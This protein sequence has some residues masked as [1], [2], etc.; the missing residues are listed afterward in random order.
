MVVLFAITGLLAALALCVIDFVTSYSG[1]RSVM[2]PG[3]ESIILRSIPFLFAV[4]A[5]TFNG[6]SAHLFRHFRRGRYG[7]LASFVLLVAWVN[8]LAYD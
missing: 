8:F 7:G 3:T 6:T 5:I 2:P 1:V 4:L